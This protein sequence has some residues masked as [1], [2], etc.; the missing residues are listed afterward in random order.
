MGLEVYVDSEAGLI[1]IVQVES[2]HFIDILIQ[3]KHKVLPSC[4]TTQILVC[5]V[6]PT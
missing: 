1:F 6:K 2:F 3:K 5:C 4:G